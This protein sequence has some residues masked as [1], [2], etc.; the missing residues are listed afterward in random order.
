MTG[1]AVYQLCPVI[2]TQPLT[3]RRA[4]RSTVTQ[5]P[6][7]PPDA[8]DAKQ[9]RLWTATETDHGQT[10]NRVDKADAAAIDGL[11]D[12]SWVETCVLINCWSC[13]DKRLRMGCHWRRRSRRPECDTRRPSAVDRTARMVEVVVAEAAVPGSSDANRHSLES[14]DA[15]FV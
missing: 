9:A 14:S 11:P 4:G 8:T 5:P 6:P 1:A 2:V 15:G 10:H 12:Q 13:E 3:D 7:P